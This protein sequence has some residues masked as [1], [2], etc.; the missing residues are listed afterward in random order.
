M[1]RSWRNRTRGGR[2]AGE[3]ATIESGPGHAIL[4]VRAENGEVLLA[5]SHGPAKP[6]IRNPESETNPNRCKWDSSWGR[7]GT[8]GRLHGGRA[9]PSSGEERQR[10]RGLWT[11]RCRAHRRFL[12][13]RDFP[14]GTPAL[15]VRG[16]YPGAVYHVVNRSESGLSRDTGIGPMGAATRADVLLEIVETRADPAAAPHP[17]GH[18]SGRGVQS[19]PRSSRLLVHGRDKYHPAGTG[20]SLAVRTGRARLGRAA[21]PSVPSAESKGTMGR[22]ALRPKEPAVLSQGH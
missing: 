22:T 18:P 19:H 5:R 20:Q 16:Q 17:V 9:S 21:L 2:R 15:A 13:S 6:E 10:G 4:T 1:R 3:D 11:R 7:S 14:R 12:C 8:S